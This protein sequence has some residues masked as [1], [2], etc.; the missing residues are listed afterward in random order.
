MKEQ[1]PLILFCYKNFQ[2]KKSQSIENK[3]QMIRYGIIL[4]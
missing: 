1:N 4:K 2:M 3:S